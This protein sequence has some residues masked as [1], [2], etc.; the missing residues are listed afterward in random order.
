M[1]DSWLRV[2]RTEEAA[3]I[4]IRPIDEID[5]QPLSCLYAKAFTSVD[6]PWTPQS[7]LE[8]VT[9]WFRLQPDLAYLAQREGKL[10]GAL[11]VGIRPWCDGNHLVD[12]EFFVDPDCQQKGVGSKLLK[13]VM[14]VAKE[15]YDPVVFETYTFGGASAPLQWYKRLGFHQIE[16]WVMIRAEVKTIIAQLSGGA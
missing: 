1:K 6:E 4:K 9:Y 8:L 16:E 14:E 10:L 12:G 7:A 11:F 13:K 2:P 3:L 15:K 5:L